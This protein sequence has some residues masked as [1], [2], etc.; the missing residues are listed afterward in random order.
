MILKVVIISNG[1]QKRTSLRLLDFNVEG[2]KS[3]L[4]DPSCIKL[5]QQFDIS[6]LTETWKRDTSKLDLEAFSDFSQVRQNHFNAIRHSGGMTVLVKNTIRQGVRLAEDPEGFIWLRLEKSFFKLQ[7]D[8]FLCEAYVPLSN[9]TKNIHSKTDYFGNLENSILKYREKGDILIMGDLNSRTGREGN[10]YHENNKYITE[11]APENN[12]KTS[13]KGDRSSCDDKTNTSSWKLLNICHNHNINIANGQIPG[14]RLGNFTCLNNL[15]A[16]VV[17]YLLAD[18]NIWEK[19]LKFKVLNPTFDA[20]HA[21]IMA[22]LKLSTSKLGKEKLLNPP[23]SYKWNDQGC[24]IF[25]SILNL[26]GKKTNHNLT[27]NS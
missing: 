17:E 5:V 12:N 4:E 1:T 14:D 26:P 7:N 6:V 25:K 8:V 23:K 15:G 20:E 21:P 19:M 2:L 18:R 10:M 27:G 3:K 9:T 13:L 16:S 22:T 11:I 24:T